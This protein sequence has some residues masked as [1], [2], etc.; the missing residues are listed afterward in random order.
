M[1]VFKKLSDSK[2]LT[3]PLTYTTEEGKEHELPIKAP[4]EEQPEVVVIEPTEI[5][6]FQTIWAKEHL[7]VAEVFK[8]AISQALVL[9]RAESSG[10]R[11]ALENLRDSIF[12]FLD[13]IANTAKERE[14]LRH[15]YEGL[16][17]FYPDEWRNIEA[18]RENVRKAV[19]RVTNEFKRLLS[20][21]ST[22][23]GAAYVLVNFING[24]YD[25]E[26]ISR[27][28]RTS[29]TM[30]LGRERK[31]PTFDAISVDLAALNALYGEA[32]RIIEEN[33]EKISTVEQTLESE[34]ELIEK[35]KK[36]PEKYRPLSPEE[37]A[38]SV[39]KLRKKWTT[40]RGE[41]KKLAEFARQKYNDYV[42]WKYVDRYIN[43][44]ASLD[45]EDNPYAI[46]ELL[47]KNS[48]MDDLIYKN[49]FIQLFNEFLKNEL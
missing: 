43:K 27:I 48:S 33:K 9:L 36:A 38:R 46:E 35:V 5:G 24:L 49:L 42:F 14:E 11:D 25:D 28:L 3:V 17:P 41:L 30:Y 1:V 31:G 19:E 23:A 37:I 20:N 15:E 12:R 8:E 21:D 7:R 34:K 39:E 22:K 45:L 2:F 32:E 47:S 29:F 44:L 13:V 6:F 10:L 40:K 4:E 18:L 26:V 16:V